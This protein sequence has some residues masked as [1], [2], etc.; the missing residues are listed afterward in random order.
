VIMSPL[1]GV[2]FDLV[3]SIGF[4]SFQRPGVLSLAGRHRVFCF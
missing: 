2:F 1:S 3:V 4:S